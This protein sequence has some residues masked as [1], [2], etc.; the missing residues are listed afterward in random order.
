[1]VQQ[2]RQ[3]HKEHRVRK[4]LLEAKVEQAFKVI[5]ER[6]EALVHK[7][8]LV[9]K[10]EQEVRVVL[11]LKV[12]PVR[13][14]RLV[15]KEPLAHRERQDLKEQLEL[16]VFRQHRLLTSIPRPLRMQIPATTICASIMPI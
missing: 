9:H 1:V 6:R 11:E 15:R 8:R 12:R 5:L 14:E 2:V 3:V 13:R 10:A 7:E 4:E 16:M